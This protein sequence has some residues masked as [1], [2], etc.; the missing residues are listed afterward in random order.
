MEF[1]DRVA[2][3]HEKIIHDNESLK[4]NYNIL[5]SV[6][7]L[8]HVVITIISTLIG[9]SKAQTMFL[10]WIATTNIDWTYF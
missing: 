1:V 10:T 2:E 9:N 3:Q 6:P 4:N 5:T 7:G 8:G